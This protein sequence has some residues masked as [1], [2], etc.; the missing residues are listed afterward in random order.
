MADGPYFHTRREF[1]GVSAS[2]A[3]ALATG[4]ENLFA[5]E[6]DRA[7]RLAADA[8]PVKLG[9]VGAGG[10]GT[11][12][13]TN[14][15]KI[16]GVQYLAICDIWPHSQ[17]VAANICR[18][19]GGPEPRI[20]TEYA[21]FLDK[22]KDLE[23]VVV[24]VPDWKHAEVTNACLRAGKH[25]YCEKEMAKTIEGA[26]SM[27]TTARET[28]KIL[29][30]GHQRH[31][32]PLYKVAHELL[33]KDKIC[34]RVTHVRAQFNRNFNGRRPS[35]PAEDFDCQKYGYP[36]MA[37]LRDWRLYKQTGGGWMADLA[38]HQVDVLNWMLDAPPSSVMAS[39]GIDYYLDEVDAQGKPYPPREWYDNVLAIF[40]YPDV[41][42]GKGVVRVQYQVITT[43]GFDEF[44]E[45]IMG[46]EG[47][48]FL[49][50]DGGLAFREP[51]KKKL[52]WEEEAAKTKVVGREAI[53][54]ALG[55]SLRPGG[56]LRMLQKRDAG[57]KIE[58]KLD[59]A[60]HQYALEDFVN[61]LITGKNAPGCTPEFGFLTTVA[62]T[63]ASDA[64]ESGVKHVFKPE[65]YV[66]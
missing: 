2:V 38:S 14:S 44:Y 29:A 9:I 30:I 36:T 66:A 20:Y 10:E 25:V 1:L 46:D 21:E 37:H 23:A 27:V 65:D 52:T 13:M 45:Q 15:L 62:C 55:R 40:E 57:R 39:G 59:K 54:L 47:T 43:N 58:V 19:F 49:S 32:N 34:G 5:D 35:N 26:R 7:V 56:A 51:G 63:A 4:I 42:A 17:E 11:W 12:L 53:T 6:A 16:P 60:E 22:E 31:S 18:Q 24:A 61:C 33:H 50:S 8:R 3:A 64:A 48:L 41:P 28:K